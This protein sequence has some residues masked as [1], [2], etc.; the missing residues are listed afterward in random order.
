MIHRLSNP[1]PI[2]RS[3]SAVR[4]PEPSG[5]NYLPVE[6]ARATLIRL[7]ETAG[8]PVAAVVQ[9]VSRPSYSEIRVES[10]T[11]QEINHTMAT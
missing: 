8:M 6:L 3:A 4:E 9:Q 2:W 1:G 11:A 7:A 10:R 5:L